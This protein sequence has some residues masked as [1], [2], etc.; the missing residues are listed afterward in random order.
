M[1]FLNP[2][3]LF[4]LLTTSIPLLIHLFSRRRLQ[5]IPFSSL[6]FL[7]KIERRRMRWLRIR[8][9]LLLIVRMLALA[10]LFLA[11]AKPIVRGAL[12][13]GRIGK[14]ET[15]YLLIL[16]NSYSMGLKVRGQGSGI[17][18]KKTI[19]DTAKKKALEILDLFGQGDEGFLILS[20]DH[21]E[22]IFETPV[23]DKNLLEKGIRSAPLS[24]RK[25]D[26]RPALERG[27]EL[28]KGSKKFN[29]EIY[30]ISDF[31][32]LG[33]TS[34][35]ENPKFQ[36][37]LLE[38]GEDEPILNLIPVGEG[39]PNH[40]SLDEVIFSDP[41]F[42]PGQSFQL[43]IHLHHH[44]QTSSQKT[45]NLFLDGN[46]RET[47]EVA[48]EPQ[49]TS[50][51]SFP[52]QFDTRGYHTGYFQISEDALKADDQR[53]FSLYIPE[54]IRVLLVEGKEGEGFYLVRAL[55]PSEEIP[56]I[57]LTRM[58]SSEELDREDLSPYHAIGL[59]NVKNLSSSSLSR[60]LEFV[61]RGGGLLI[62]LGE[63]VEIPFYTEP[64]Q[65]LFSVQ[66]SPP[67]RSPVDRSRFLTPSQLDFSHPLLSVFSDPKSG[68]LT[69]IK[70]FRHLPLKERKETRVLARFK[71]GSPLLIE[72][73][74]RTLL[75]AIP[76]TLEWSDFPLKAL[77]VPFFH[78]V[79]RYLSQ[80]E[81]KN[82]VLSVGE[83][84]LA[85]LDSLKE[86]IEIQ[87]PSGETYFLEPSFDPRGN[88][89]LRFETTEVPGFYTL[90]SGEVP[91]PFAVNLPSEESDC[92]PLEK[93][94]ILKL[95]QPTFEEK[96]RWID[97]E[98]PLR[99]SLFRSSLSTDLTHPFLFLT[100]FLL[101]TEMV[102]AGR[103][104]FLSRGEEE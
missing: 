32:R 76:P 99:P 34:I 28:L 92:S 68:D 15:A 5:V 95:L 96:I 11:L 12:P 75:M 97:R 40:T 78:R 20:S 27:L 73:N 8:Q 62:S 58:I 36:S 57:F 25:T 50:I 85:R 44:S 17:S 54:K 67:E 33:F 72:G 63:E 51:A 23:H 102:I 18:E 47:R 35:I 83:P 38:S 31:Q 26:F 29:R 66:S 90:K 45:V 84:I 70:F 14:G 59:L 98:G 104:N 48:L 22:T 1:S 42:L 6:E 7:K 53:F 16:D 37:D 24:Y 9:I 100:F 3:A 41:L 77:F 101:L 52:L 2:L 61:D 103:W 65:R 10:F 94:E 69:L 87:S 81:E 21:A 82:L 49:K 71:N 43:R 60:I 39:E 46:L 80:D 30:L 55:S 79:F 64:L 13:F 19:F 91:I 89:S 88:L 4:G 56:S 74:K 86:K 93:E